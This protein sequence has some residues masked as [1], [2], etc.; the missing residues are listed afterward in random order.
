[1]AIDFVHYHHTDLAL[2]TWSGDFNLNAL[3]SAT[4]AYMLAPAEFEILDIRR[5]N[6]D[7]ISS[8]DLFKLAEH[9]RS[10]YQSDRHVPGKTAIVYHE[11]I[12]LIYSS[13]QRL[14]HSFSIWA[15]EHKLPRNFAL[16]PTMADAIAWLGSRK[17][18]DLH[19]GNLLSE[20]PGDLP[21][22]ALS[23]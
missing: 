2:H 11:E 17:I 8:M 5:L 10:A 19:A 9:L 15:K 14:F 12:P 7:S 3:L 6:L 20:T 1:M 22:Q 13:S 16:F 18:H 4:R 21:D 23:A